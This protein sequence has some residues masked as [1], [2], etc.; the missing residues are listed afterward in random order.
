MP[1]D[2]YP[3]NSAVRRDLVTRVM[4]NRGTKEFTAVLLMVGDMESDS[5]SVGAGCKRLGQARAGG[6]ERC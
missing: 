1:E 6:A 3:V 4:L 5:Y 2:V